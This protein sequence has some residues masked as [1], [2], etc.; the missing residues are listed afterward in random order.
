MAYS[1]R[2]GEVASELRAATVPV[3]SKLESLGE[4]PDIIHGHHHYETLSALL[5]FP[6]TP[7]ISYCHGWLP[8]E[9]APL[10]F[11]RILRYVAVD[12][13]C[14]ERL[15]AEGGIAPGNIRLLLNF[16]DAALF[17]ARAPLPRKPETALAFSN[18]FSENT[19]L[20]VLREACRRHGV[21]LHVAGIA[22]GKAEANTGSMLA[23]YDLVF[24][25]A[26]A[27]IE[28]MAVGSAVVLCTPG[29]MGGMVKVQNFDH[30]RRLNFGI[31]TLSRP[32]DVDALT[33]EIHEYNAADAM[34]VSATVRA[35]CELKPAVD[36]LVNLYR[37]V[38]AE[39]SQAPLKV[40]I[41]ADQAAARYLE[42]C[43]PQYKH[44]ELELDRNRWAERCLAAESEI[45]RRNGQ[46]EDLELDRSKWVARCLAAEQ[47]NRGVCVD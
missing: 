16:F 15:I 30:A 46:V 45:Q 22:A 37:E 19:G 44:T 12:E 23:K 3:I 9:E 8:W 34:A 28:A 6:E 17:P 36:Q 14:R 5:H 40:S 10:R 7:A 2:L 24:A 47:A 13:V 41:A 27:A 35:S 18:L 11:P 21:E 29:R 39:A 26:R 20:P 42:E 1:T 32:L 38:I 4:A 31:R 33:N 43:A 25:K